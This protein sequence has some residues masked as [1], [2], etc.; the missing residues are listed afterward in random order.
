MEGNYC[1]YLVTNLV[2]RKV[3]VGQS[4]NFNNR[5]KRHK[6]RAENGQGDSDSFYNAIRKYGW[7]NFFWRILGYCNTREEAGEA[8]I[9]C[10]LFF[11]SHKK[12]YGYNIQ[13]TTKRNY[14]SPGIKKET[15][16][17]F[18]KERTGEGN[19]FFG[20]TH[21]EQWK[22]ETSERTKKRMTGKKLS[23]NWKTNIG[24]SISGEKNG[25]W[26]NIDID[27]LIQ[28]YLCVNNFKEVAKI[29][30]IGVGVVY[31][32]LHRY[33]SKD[34]IY[35]TFCLFNKSSNLKRRTI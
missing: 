27:K 19:P 7:D 3:Y 8:E 11:Q 10:I 9:E 25:N 32:R 15:K 2:N 13:T 31:K 5:K 16:K 12:K 34:F 30:Y 26:K 17:R 4:N 1:I 14:S 21:T 20:K 35:A 22:K 29:N 23:E 6:Q 18:S 33:L 28:D 24:I